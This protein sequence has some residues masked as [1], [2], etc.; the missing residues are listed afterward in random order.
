M[1]SSTTSEHIMSA[2]ALLEYATN[3]GSPSYVEITDI[4][5]ITP[6]GETTGEAEDTQLNSPSATKEFGPGWVDPGE[7]EFEVYNLGTQDRT[8]QAFTR[9]MLAWRVT[10]PKLSTQNTNGDRHTFRGF[11]KTRK[12]SQAQVSSDD[13]LKVTYT[14]KI[15]GPI[16]MAAGS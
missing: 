4:T 7:F 3:L 5:S 1:P 12:P 10:L 6:P 16:T 15:S 8:L 9:T 14:V 11:I 2:G 13:R